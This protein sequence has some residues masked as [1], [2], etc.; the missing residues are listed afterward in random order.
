MPTIAAAGAQEPFECQWCGHTI[1][2]DQSA[3]AH[4]LGEEVF[5][6]I[7]Y[8][9]EPT[10]LWC[11]LRFASDIPFAAQETVECAWC[12]GPIA[13]G[14]DVL[15]AS[16]PVGEA[17]QSAER[18]GKAGGGLTAAMNTPAPKTATF[19]DLS[20]KMKLKFRWAG[21]GNGRGTRIPY[22]AEQFL[23][24]TVPG[25]VRNL[26]SK[27]V[28]EF[29]KGKDASHIESF[30]NAPSKAKSVRNILWESSRRNGRRG[31]SNMSRADRLFARA[32]NRTDAAGI[33]AKRMA[34]GAAK[35][36]ALAALMEVPV[37]VAVNTIRTTK[38]RISKREAAKRVASD[39]AT[40]AATGGVV[41][42]VTVGAVALGAGPAVATLAPVLAPIGMAV[43]GISAARRIGGAL[44]D[45]QRSAF[46]P[47]YFH[48]SCVQP[49]T[50]H[51][52]AA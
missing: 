5:H 29:V 50:M 33:V 13:A 4:I 15:R 30:A 52:S 22:E 20:P 49:E 16:M 36:A 14:E 45:D 28:D 12:D 48:S 32:K 38:G 7:C 18:Q 39:T 24:G 46:R 21:L 27:A 17:E 26:G 9:C 3:L 23:H 47:L 41:G 25:P 35:G 51:S 44:R 2:E 40:A 10:R 37:T 6:I 19:S 34:A 42:A 43:C 8:E 11:A 1:L 31:K